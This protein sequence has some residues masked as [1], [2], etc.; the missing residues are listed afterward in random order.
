LV[1]TTA[2][3]VGRFPRG[4]NAFWA[5]YPVVARFSTKHDEGYQGLNTGPF[6]LVAEN[7]ETGHGL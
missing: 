1:G 6:E 5:G 2:S 7:A 4:V 3:N